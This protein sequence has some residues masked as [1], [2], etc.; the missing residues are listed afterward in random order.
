MQTYFIIYY[1]G[2]IIYINILYII[3]SVLCSVT[4]T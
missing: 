3:T 2:I 1:D 4:P